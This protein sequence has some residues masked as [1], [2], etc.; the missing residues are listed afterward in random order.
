MQIVD[1]WTSLNLHV[2]VDTRDTYRGIHPNERGTKGC[3]V[4]RR[5]LFPFSPRS[6]VRGSVVKTAN[7][8]TG[9]STYVSRALLV[10]L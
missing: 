10:Q 3:R 5:F 8:L 1:R 2:P 9:H 6:P 7:M 4:A